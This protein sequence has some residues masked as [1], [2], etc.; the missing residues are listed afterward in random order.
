MADSISL[1]DKKLQRKQ[2]QLKGKEF[3]Q[4]QQANAEKEIKEMSADVQKDSRSSR[5]KSLSEAKK[6]EMLEEYERVVKKLKELEL[7]NKKK[8]DFKYKFK[9]LNY[10][11]TLNGHSVYSES[12]QSQAKADKDSISAMMAYGQLG[13]GFEVTFEQMTQYIRP[14]RKQEFLALC[15][16]NPELSHNLMGMTKV[17]QFYNQRDF[18]RAYAAMVFFGLENNMDLMETFLKVKFNADFKQ[19]VDKF[20]LQIAMASSYE[21]KEIRTEAGTNVF[22]QHDAATTA[23][24]S[25]YTGKEVDFTSKEVRVKMFSSNKQEKSETKK[26]KE[27][28][29]QVLSDICKAAKEASGGDVEKFKKEAHKMLRT[30]VD[31]EKTEK[32]LDIVTKENKV[33]E[34]IKS[35]KITSVGLFGTTMDTETTLDTYTLITGAEKAKLDAKVEED[36]QD[37]MFVSL[38]EEIEKRKKAMDENPTPENIAAYKQIMGVVKARN[39]ARAEELKRPDKLLKKA[40][41]K[42]SK[43]ETE[44]EKESLEIEIAE[45]EFEC[46]LDVFL[47][48]KEL[49]NIKERQDSEKDNFTHMLQLKKMITER[50]MFLNEAKKA[51]RYKE[52]YALYPKLVQLEQMIGEMKELNRKKASA[53]LGAIKD[54]KVNEKTSEWFSSFSVENHFNILNKTEIVQGVPDSTFEVIKDGLINGLSGQGT[55]DIGSSEIKESTLEQSE[56][57][58]DISTL[59]KGIGPQIRYYENNHPNGFSGWIDVEISKFETLIEQALSQ[60]KSLPSENISEIQSL[61]ADIEKYRRQIDIRLVYKSKYVEYIENEEKLK[62]SKGKTPEEKIQVALKKIDS[63]LRT[64]IDGR[65]EYIDELKPEEVPARIT[66]KTI[67]NIVNMVLDLLS[68]INELELS[69]INEE[70]LSKINIYLNKTSNLLEQLQGKISEEEFNA[71]KGRKELLS[72]NFKK[73]SE[74]SSKPNAG[75]ELGSESRVESPQEL[76]SLNINSIKILKREAVIRVL[77]RKNISLETKFSRVATSETNGFDDTFEEFKYSKK[78]MRRFLANQRKNLENAIAA[79]ENAEKIEELQAKIKRIEDRIR[80]LEIEHKHLSSIRME[81]DNSPSGTGADALFAETE[82]PPSEPAGQTGLTAEKAKEEAEIE[83]ALLGK[84]PPK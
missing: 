14:E 47:D 54:Y 32:R 44:E 31:A 35:G 61:T 84:Q 16:N 39:A 69:N 79:G 65:Q 62:P 22:S 70:T 8:E 27:G 64:P 24:L 36:F 67:K 57:G 73:L 10:F 56:G 40:R 77:E 53:N 30:V 3:K 43:A 51:G 9:N 52:G 42:L 33:V 75:E 80:E 82:F 7:R 45:L 34:G 74:K 26:I 6:K 19:Q 72:E 21:E 50:E 46:K 66:D 2:N 5:L 23:I 20:K 28:Q 41:E 37:I 78:G 81:F 60:I 13:A 11:P 68:E 76:V 17:L 48:R 12:M 49:E 59:L 1:K 15:K 25:S 55:V 29:I 63:K 83:I 18:T 71:L 38:T 58:L 4:E